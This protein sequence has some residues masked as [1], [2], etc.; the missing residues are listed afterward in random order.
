MSLWCVFLFGDPA[1]WQAFAAIAQVLLALAL[2]FVTLRYVGL[3]GELVKLQADIVKLEKKSNQR[4]L[5]DR[6]LKVYESV[7][8]FLGGFAQDV[9]VELS[10]IMQLYRDTRDAEFLFGDEIPKYIEHVAKTAHEYRVLN[11]E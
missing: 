8:A 4:E 10:G 7:M 9:K 3:T 2:L 5:Y 6:R 1:W 11:L